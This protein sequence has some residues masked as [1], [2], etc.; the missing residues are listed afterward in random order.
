M[1]FTLPSSL[2]RGQP[3]FRIY[4]VAK[5]TLLRW[6]SIACYSEI[7][8]ALLPKTT[9][10]FIIEHP[11]PTGKFTFNLFNHFTFTPHCTM[12]LNHL[13][14]C[15]RCRSSCPDGKHISSATY[16]RHQKTYQGVSKNQHYLLCICVDY[17]SRHILTKSSYYQHLNQLQHQ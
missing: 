13:C 1:I 14:I 17:P 9:T 16:Y 12:P 3:E 6:L 2:T 15:E 10:L 5:T 4:F 11:S 7:G 8:G